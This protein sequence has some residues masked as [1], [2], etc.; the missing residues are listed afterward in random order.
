MTA[1]AVRFPPPSSC[2]PER[3]RG[4][5]HVRDG[6]EHDFRAEA[7]GLLAEDLHELG[8]LDPVAKARIVLDLG[9]DRQLAAGLRALDHDRLELGAR[10]VEGG[11]PAGGARADDG[12][13][14]VALGRGHS[15]LPSGA[16]DI[17]ASGSPARYRYHRVV[18]R[19]AL[20]RKLEGLRHDDLHGD[21]AP[22]QRARG[23][24]SVAGVSG[25]RRPR[26][27]EGGGDRGSARRARAVRAHERHPR[28]PRGAVGEVPARLR[29]R[30]TRR[31][32]RSRSPPAR[33][34]R[35]S[36]PSRA[37]ATP[38][39]RSSCSSPYYDSY[40]PSVAM[41]GAAARVVTLRAPDWSFDREECAPP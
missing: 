39:T 22:R 14:V 13:A 9:R 32:P 2:E 11:G 38:A 34:R 35:S 15:C 28:D 21:D 19:P 40:K 25:L 37:S 33:P 36:R 31:T 26:L 20:S 24:Q 27:R 5:V 23:R 10:G 4:E 29:A 6:V 16:E 3:A 30:P 1:S 7:L 12:D 41:A 8:T 17:S 18:P